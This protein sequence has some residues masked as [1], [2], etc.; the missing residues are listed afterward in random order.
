MKSIVDFVIK[1]PF[2][3][4]EV[5]SEL[6]VVL[7]SSAKGIWFKGSCGMAA[8][9][10]KRLD[11]SVQAVSTLIPTILP[12]RYDTADKHAVTRNQRE[13]FCAIILN[14]SRGQES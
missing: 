7:G 10:A 9:R 5:R 14:V 12:N 3:F 2:S 1:L 13:G 6:T 8:E 4:W 11:V